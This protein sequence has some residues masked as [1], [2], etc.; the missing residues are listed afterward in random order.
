MD[1][2]DREGDPFRA[3]PVPMKHATESTTNTIPIDKIPRTPATAKQTPAIANS[4]GRVRRA[5]NTPLRTAS[6]PPIA[7]ANQTATSN[8]GNTMSTRDRRRN[9][10]P[11]ELASPIA[12]TV[13][14][15]CAGTSARS[16]STSRQIWRYA[17]SCPRSADNA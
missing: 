1:A 11:W 14:L 6:N 3:R 2:L 8:S 7:D 10:P 4:R 5:P 17:K 15:V 13:A 16:S 12:G 9:I